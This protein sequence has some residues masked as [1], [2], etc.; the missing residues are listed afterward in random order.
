VDAWDFMGG[1]RWP[2]GVDPNRVTL[3]AFLGFAH[4][5]GITPRLMRPEE[6]FAPQVD[7]GM[8]V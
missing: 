6:I 5:Q 1:E 2:Y 3:E 4:R 7:G 8:R